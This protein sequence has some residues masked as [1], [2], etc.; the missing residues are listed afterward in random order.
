[1]KF[2]VRLVSLQSASGS[3]TPINDHVP[4]LIYNPSPVS[5]GIAITAEAVSWLPH[6]TTLHRKPTSFTT[7]SRRLP[8]SLPGICSGRNISSGYPSRRIRSLSHCFVTGS[9]NCVDVPLVYSETFLPV[10]RNW[11]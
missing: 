7:L 6:S 9:T 3:S 5:F 8:T 10:R 4:E 11:K 1:M 2:A